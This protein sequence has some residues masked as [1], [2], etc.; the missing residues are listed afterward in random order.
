[1]PWSIGLNDLDAA[2]DWETQTFRCSTGGCKLDN[3]VVGNLYTG[4]LSDDTGFLFG[5]HVQVLQH[6]I[7]LNRHTAELAFSFAAGS[8]SEVEAD[9]VFRGSVVRA[10]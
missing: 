8:R 1:L 10:K 5:Q 4:K 6:T 7:T 3:K 9:R 2:H